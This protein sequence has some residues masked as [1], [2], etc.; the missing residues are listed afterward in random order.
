M[1][2]ITSSEKK[3]L[4]HDGKSN[5]YWWVCT[6]QLDK[7]KRKL[8]VKYCW[9]VVSIKLKETFLVIVIMREEITVNHF[10]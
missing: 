1:T 3:G 8:L 10:T 4:M 9:W 2:K 7:Q 5:F 6:T